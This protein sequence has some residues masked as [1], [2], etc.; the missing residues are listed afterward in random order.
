VA[1]YYIDRKTGQKIEEI[2][3]GGKSL[4]WL[5]ET[6]AGTLLLQI[7]VRRKIFSALYGKLQDTGFSSRKITRFIRDL[8]IDM[9]E[10][11]CEDPSAYRTFNDFFTREL[12]PESRPLATERGILISPADGKV[13]AWEN[14]DA[15]QLFQIKGLTYSLSDLLQDKALAAEYCGGA[16]LV[17]RLCPADYHRFHFPDDG[18]PLKAQK[19]SGSYYS[20]NPMALRKIPGLFCENKRELT[21]FHSQNF[22]RIL[23]L[24]VGA[25]CVGS[26]VQTFS[27]ELEVKKGALKGYFKFGGSTVILFL[28]PG[29]VKIDRDLL[30]NTAEG[31]ETKV[32]MGERLG[33]AAG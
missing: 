3:A 5:Y 8:N 33:C 11:C 30:E 2:V 23:L 4:R 17:I 21:I 18:I 27:P 12:K 31:F 16:C 20:V 29:S 9:T 15:G 13:S 1:I 32:C 28:K 22:G 25:T 7:L 24:E 6:K 10:A 19:F 14:I 26:I